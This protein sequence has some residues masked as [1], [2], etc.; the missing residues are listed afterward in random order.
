MFRVDARRT[1]FGEWYDP[2]SSNLRFFWFSLIK[3]F[4]NYRSKLLFGFSFR[5]QEFLLHINRSNPFIKSHPWRKT[6]LQF[7]S[8]SLAQKSMQIQQLQKEQQLNNIGKNI[9]YLTI[10]STH[11]WK[12]KNNLDFDIDNSPLQTYHSNISC[13]L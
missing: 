12:I 2:K 11:S 9:H 5:K 1:G 4:S 7:L 13:N 10:I 8:E 3:R 6:S